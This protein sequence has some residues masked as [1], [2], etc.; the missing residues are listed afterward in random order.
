MEGHRDGMPGLERWEHISV[1]FDYLHRNGQS[2]AELQGDTGHPWSSQGANLGHGFCL[3]I[4][5]RALEGN[6]LY[7]FLFFFS[8]W[9]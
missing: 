3:E 9:K 4:V 2:L 5:F 1:C 8:A 6:N 7:F